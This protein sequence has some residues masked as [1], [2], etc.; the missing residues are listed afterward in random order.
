VRASAALTALAV[1]LLVVFAGV[2]AAAPTQATGPQPIFTAFSLVK[3]RALTTTRCGQYR[4]TRGTYTGRATSPDPRVAG[5]VT[6]TGRIVRTAGGS[7]GIATG[8]IVIRDSR[9]RVRMRGTLS[10]VFSENS[11]V[12]G[13]VTARLFEP[14]ARLLANVTLVFDDVLGFAAVRLGMESGANSA[15]AYPA[16]PDC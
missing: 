2:G 7:H 14:A 4:I 16:V 3:Q 13:L 9:G 1:A 6:Y 15:V 10:G 11:V 5:H 8:S 12:N